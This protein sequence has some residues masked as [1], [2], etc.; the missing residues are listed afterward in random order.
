MTLDMTPRLAV[1]DARDVRAIVG[2]FQPQIREPV[3]A[4][5]AYLLNLAVRHLRVP[6][7]CAALGTTLHHHVPSVVGA[8]SDK[9]MNG[10]DAPR[11]VADVH[12]FMAARYNLP[13]KNNSETV[14]VG[15]DPIHN[16]PSVAGRRA[17]TRPRPT[18]FRPARLIGAFGKAWFGRLASIPTWARAIPTCHRR[19]PHVKDVPAVLAFTSRVLGGRFSHDNHYRSSCPIAI[20]G[21]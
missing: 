13:A 8:S 19:F 5:I 3:C 12:H 1:N 10:I 14:R 18:C 17:R 6:V 9:Q 20:G 16:E 7:S 4:E 11:I 15:L 2:S 21:Y